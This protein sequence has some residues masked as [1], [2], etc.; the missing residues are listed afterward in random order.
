MNNEFDYII[1]GTGSAGSI[2]ANRLSKK[3]NTKVLALEAG[4]SDNNFG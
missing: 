2:V 3:T 1:V 4:G